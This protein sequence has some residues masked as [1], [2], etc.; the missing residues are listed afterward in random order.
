MTVHGVARKLLQDINQ[1]VEQ[2][3]GHSKKVK[4]EKHKHMKK[5]TLYLG[6]N[7]QPK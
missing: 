7:K 1:W 6:N 2:A 5:V 4:Q 3:G